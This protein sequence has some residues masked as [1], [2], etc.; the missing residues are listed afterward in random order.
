[1]RF[2]LAIGLVLALWAKA[3]SDAAFSQQGW[4][5]E[6]ATSPIDD[7]KEFR[8]RF[9]GARLAFVINCQGGTAAAGL[10]AREVLS[11]GTSTDVLMRIDRG[12]VTSRLWLIS[13]DQAYVAGYNARELLNQMLNGTSAHF[14]VGSSEVSV[15]LQQ[16]QDR[17]HVLK[18]A[19][20][21]S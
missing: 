20:G 18:M 7:R 2:V 15:P 19:C 12:E 14:R 3:S 13:R 5:I 8:A 9:E 17:L 21:I 10:M 1:M 4:Q 6:E 16:I 11:L